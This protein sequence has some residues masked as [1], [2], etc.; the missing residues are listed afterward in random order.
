MQKSKIVTNPKHKPL[1][2]LKSLQ[3]KETKGRKKVTDTSSKNEAKKLTKIT[4]NQ[5]MR[6]R[7]K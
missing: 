6:T 7:P 2:L 3:R 4:Q 1:P 5:R